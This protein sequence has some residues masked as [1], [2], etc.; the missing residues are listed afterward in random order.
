MSIDVGAAACK[1]TNPSPNSRTIAPTCTSEGYRLT[2]CTKCSG[3]LSKTNYTAKLPHNS[4]GYKV[5]KYATCGAMGSAA[6]YCTGCNKTMSTVTIPATGQH[7]LSSFSHDISGGYQIGTSL[8]DGSIFFAVTDAK[9]STFAYGSDVMSVCFDAEETYII[10][11]YNFGEDKIID[12]IIEEI[13]PKA[14]TIVINAETGG[15]ASGGGLYRNGD[16]VMLQAIPDEGYMFD[17]WYENGKKID[18][19][20]ANYVLTVNSNRTIEAKFVPYQF[21]VT[22]IVIEGIDDN[23]NKPLTFTA[24]VIGGSGTVKHTFYILRNGKI[25]YSNQNSSIPV[26]S[27]EAISSGTYTAIV[28]SID[29]IGNKVSYIKQFTIV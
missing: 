27:Y 21:E 22:D 15:T 7:S 2:Y 29:E 6:R 25:Y 4:N 20:T 12:F 1:C 10:E 13:N 9:G 5:A 28:Y 16:L 24:N 11:I 8:A 14:Y 3:E 17:G 23:K 19:A 18:G 26:F